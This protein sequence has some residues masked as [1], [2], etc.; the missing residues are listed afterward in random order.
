MAERYRKHNKLVA[1]LKSKVE[2]PVCLAIP[3]EGPMASCPKGHLVCLP[4]HQTMVTSGQV[5]C[6]KCRLVMLNNTSLLAKTVIE[7]IEHEC[8][9]E[10]CKKKI[11]Q[12]EL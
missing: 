4:C 11:G 12:K 1:E 2:C 9:N 6:P 5:N 3:T 7:N 8:P 10:G